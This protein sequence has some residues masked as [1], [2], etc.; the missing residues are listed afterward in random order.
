MW[1]VEEVEVVE[2]ESDLYR[3]GQSLFFEGSY[4]EAKK[5]F[6]HLEEA[7]QHP[8]H[9]MWFA[10][11]QFALGEFDELEIPDW[12][13]EDGRLSDGWLLMGI[14]AAGI[15]GDREELNRLLEISEKVSKS[16]RVSVFLEATNMEPETK[17][18]AQ[19][20]NVVRRYVRK[21]QYVKLLRI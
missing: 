4:E 11:C 12:I 5:I 3:D 8:N 10:R 18:N 21:K 1:E 13:I 2:L 16:K 15:R 20:V 19:A 6:A 9:G 14:F 17:T 7:E